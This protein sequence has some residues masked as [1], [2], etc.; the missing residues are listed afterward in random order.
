MMSDA[1][2]YQWVKFVMSEEEH[3]RACAMHG[4]DVPLNMWFC[5]GP[6]SCSHV[7]QVRS[8]GEWVYRVRPYPGGELVA[9]ESAFEAAA[10]VA[11]RYSATHEAQA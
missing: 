2:K 11:E 7:E 8:E 6:I 3:Q 10:S 9:E 5:D 4:P 1:S